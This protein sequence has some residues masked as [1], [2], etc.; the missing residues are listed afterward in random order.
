MQG[1]PLTRLEREVIE[2]RLKG[3]VPLRQIGRLLHRDHGVISREIRRNNTRDGTYSA[4][5]A[6]ELAERRR[7]TR[8]GRKRKLDTDDLLRS[9][10]VK[11]LRNGRSPDAIAGRLKRRP[12]QGLQGRTVSQ[13]SIYQW[14]YDGEGRWLGLHQYLCRGR[15]KRQRRY[16]RK[17]RKAH[18]QGRISIHARPT[19]IDERRGYG[20]WESDSMV[21][22]KQRQ[23]LSVQYERKAKY[24]LIHRLSDGSSESTERALHD[25]V[26][27]LPQELWKSITFDN[28]GEGACHLTFQKDF[29]ID[30]YFCD[31]YSSW[32][33]GGVENANG[34]IRRFLPRTTDLSSLTDDDIYAIQK[35]INST[36][37]KSLG[38]LTPEEALAEQ[39][40]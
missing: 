12:A 8:Q 30:T 16:A 25:S 14:I 13:E 20:H 39:P 27:S 34:I 33:K 35:R 29:G 38:Y 7:K 15:K 11:E 28:G 18:I 17:A 6:D 10:V 32:Q 40:I 26:S 4:V 23:R 9:H 36:Q 24:T 31:P 3:H 2:L 22:S 21:F 37:R 5:H 19:A 1:S